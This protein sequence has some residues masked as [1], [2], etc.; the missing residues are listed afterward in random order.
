MNFYARPWRI[1]R[2]AAALVVLQVSLVARPSH[3]GEARTPALQQL[4]EAAKAE[5]GRFI[6]DAVI[7]DARGRKEAEVAM[8]KLFGFKVTWEAVDLMNQNQ[9]ASRLLKEIQAGRQPST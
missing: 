5:G 3:A 1:F 2:L 8:E 7:D 4:I 9:F 6:A